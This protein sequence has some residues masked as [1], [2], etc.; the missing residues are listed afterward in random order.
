MNNGKTFSGYEWFSVLNETMPAG[1]VTGTAAQ[2]DVYSIVLNAVTTD[3][4]IAQQ[5]VDLYLGEPDGAHLL[6]MG[7]FGLPDITFGPL[8]NTPDREIG[9]IADTHMNRE[10]KDESQPGI[11]FEKGTFEK[12]FSELWAKYKPQG[13]GAA[14]IGRD[15]LI[16]HALNTLS[17]IIG[18]TIL[19]NGQEDDRGFRI[20][21]PDGTSRIFGW[22]GGKYTKEEKGNLSWDTLRRQYDAVRAIAPAMFDNVLGNLKAKMQ[23]HQP[24]IFKET[25]E[26]KDTT[27]GTALTVISDIEDLKFGEGD[28]PGLSERGALYLYHI[29]NYR[30]F[31]AALPDSIYI[32]P[33]EKAAID[34]IAKEVLYT[35]GKSDAKLRRKISEL[36]QKQYPFLKDLPSTDTPDSPGQVKQLLKGLEDKSPDDLWRTDPGTI[37]QKAELSTGGGYHGQ[38]EPKKESNSRIFSKVDQ[39]QKHK[40]WRQVNET[41]TS[42]YMD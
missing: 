35:G 9:G 30:I 8:K 40:T 12:M 20:L 17:S 4:V 39:T 15:V 28:T 23:K 7:M 3:T 27:E 2:Q 11:V 31:E 16:Q 32:K 18:Y 25:E 5:I 19:Q 42:R 34:N 10:V 14:D 22:A 29:L 38:L 24:D 37:P 6:L 33:E 21:M 1:G 41:D 26:I 13:E 36:L